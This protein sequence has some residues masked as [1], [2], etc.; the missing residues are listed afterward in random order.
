MGQACEHKEFW[1]MTTFFCFKQSSRHDICSIVVKKGK[2]LSVLTRIINIQLFTAMCAI[3][4]FVTLIASAIIS[5][6]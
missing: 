5:L 6:K 2:K 3:I 4:A 1:G